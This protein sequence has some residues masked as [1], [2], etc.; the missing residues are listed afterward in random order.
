MYPPPRPLLADA[1]RYFLMSRP[2]LLARR[3]IPSPRRLVGQSLDRAI[4]QNWTFHWVSPA[5]NSVGPT[6]SRTPPSVFGGGLVPS[7]PRLM[8]SASSS[9]NFQMESSSSR[10]LGSRFNASTL[11]RVKGTLKMP[12]T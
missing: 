7:P 3:G 10:N 12:F 5:G 8:L 1:S 2:P 6:R 11:G 4:L 9:I